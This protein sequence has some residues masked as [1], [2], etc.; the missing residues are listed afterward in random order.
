[1]RVLPIGRALTLENKQ[2]QLPPPTPL[3][4]H[5]HTQTHTLLPSQPEKPS[6]THC[7]HKQVITIEQLS[8]YILTHFLAFTNGKTLHHPLLLQHQ[9]S[10]S[11]LMTHMYTHTL[12][13][14]Q[15]EKPSSTCCSHTKVLTIEQL[16]KHT[17]TLAILAEKPSSTH[18]SN[19]QVI[20]M[21]QL[22]NNTY[23]HTLAFTARKALLHLL[24]VQTGD[25]H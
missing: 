2:K 17:H 25:H 5:T 19:K 10:S 15:P 13:P 23:T 16:S 18:C 20:T 21:E 6:S 7:S 24:L 22:S 9:R 4:N 3:S 14:S 12:L 11:S 1:M 8:N